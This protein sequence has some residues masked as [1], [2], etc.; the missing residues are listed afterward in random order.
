M[1][2]A[3]LAAFLVLVAA[4]FGAFLVAQRLKG[5]P[6][7]VHLSGPRGPFSPNGDG[8][9][10]VKAFGVVVRDADE[11]TVVVVD[12]GGGA[13]R[14]LAED[15]RARPSVPVPLRWDGRSDDGA[16]VADGVYH[17]RVTLGRTGRTVTVPRNLS[18]DTRAPQ[19]YV[20]AVAPSRI[21]APGER[22]TVTVGR[23]G[24]LQPTRVAL[25]RTDL[26][27]PRRVAEGELAVGR[28]RWTWDGRVAG[29][30]AAPGV[31]LAQ[32]DRT[33][34]AGNVGRV[35][36]HVPTRARIP[37][38]PGVTV[39]AVAAQPPLAPV[40]AA[41]RV[42]VQVDSRRRPYRWTLR[43][44]GARRPTASGRG[45]ST[46]LSFRAPSGASGLYVL[47]V[48]A[49]G[50]GTRVPVL[51]QARARA[52][53]LVVVPAVTW[54]GR[55]PVDDD[56]DGQP[57]TLDRGRPVR[58]PRVLPALPAGVGGDVAPLLAFL[59]RSRVRY[60]LTSD[61]ALALAGGPR[62][63]DRPGVLLAGAERWIPVA[64]GRALR[65]YV[66][67][68]GRLATVATDSLRRGVTLLSRAGG[69]SGALVRPTAPVE[70]DPFG[71]RLTGTRR[72]PA[73]IALQ[74]IAGS[75]HARLLAFWDGTLSGFTAAEESRPPAAGDGVR[76]RAGVGVVP[77]T[78]G[79]AADDEPRPA[80][81]QLT[82][83]RGTVVRIGLAGWTRRLSSD[84]EV[85]QLT[86]NAVDLL[87]GARPRARDVPPPPRERPKRRR[88]RRG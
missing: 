79:A 82:V 55:A 52:R 41:R 40:T 57:D 85:V 69:T 2:R 63:T 37:G 43:R 59:D 44:V 19:P 87:V 46:P 71:S 7:A 31:Y 61:L 88:A 73:G 3:A 35:P 47:H 6:P 62:P 21:V 15:V 77:G 67:D 66:T 83:G 50:A 4:T 27:R 34:A 18:V 39:R 16:V 74:P 17:A 38:A 33:D 20:R 32:V 56:G 25:W 12:A 78:T 36:A 54:L 14:R 11:L 81:S 84:R 22:V 76:L 28:R 45:T 75:A 23:I 24:R 70:R 58:W 30:P 68:G 1:S 53:L 72:L 60:D 13:V 42:R 65:R 29:A 64:Y 26:R 86:R 8:R 9:Q 51:V 5:A 48:R 80:L 49:G 10:D